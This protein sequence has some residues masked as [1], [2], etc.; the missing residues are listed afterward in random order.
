MRRCPDEVPDEFWPPDKPR[1]RGPKRKGIDQTLGG[2]S[3]DATSEEPPVVD[4]PRPLIQHRGESALSAQTQPIPNKGKY[5][6]VLHGHPR[7]AD[8]KPGDM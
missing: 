6:G 3:E 2:E 7:T 8:A 1:K 5:T 4:V